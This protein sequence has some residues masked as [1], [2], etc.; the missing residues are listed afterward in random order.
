MIV[1]EQ[2][3]ATK[4]RSNQDPN[5]TTS[6][7]PLILAESLPAYTP[8]EGSILSPSSAL[9]HYNP[10]PPSEAPKRQT[11]HAAKRFAKTLLLGFGAY[12]ALASLLKFLAIVIS[13]SR[14][15]VRW[16]RYSPHSFVSFGHCSEAICFSNLVPQNG[17]I[18]RA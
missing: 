12:F 1:V 18:S 2:S 7:T 9:P 3:E 16:A 5:V 4:S 13:N 17:R 15:D 10:P 6:S 14:H 11:R 8:R